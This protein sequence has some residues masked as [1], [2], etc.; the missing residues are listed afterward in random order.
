MMHHTF[1]HLIDPT[2]TMEKLSR[3]V[4]PGGSVVIRMPVAGTY[5][6]RTYG[7]DWY[8]LDAPRHIFVHTEKS[9]A[10]IAQRAGFALA[11][12]VYDSTG[13]QFWVSEQYRRDIPLKNERSYL[14]NPRG[15]VFTPEDMKRFDREAGRLNGER[16]GDQACFYLR[17]T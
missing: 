4:A 16:Q 15:S 10:I 3:I 9:L 7:A 1:E 8:Q 17:K 13:R 11:S 6:W 2:G 12:V 14:N 5:A